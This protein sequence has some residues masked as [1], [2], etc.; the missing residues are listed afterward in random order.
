MSISSRSSPMPAPYPLT[1]RQSAMSKCRWVK[2]LR[3]L[4]VYWAVG[5]FL[6]AQRG[7]VHKPTFGVGK[8]GNAR[9]V[10][11][12]LLAGPIGHPRGTRGHTGGAYFCVGAG[13]NRHS[14]GLYTK[15][16]IALGKIVKAAFT[17]KKNHLAKR[18]PAQLKTNAQLGHAGRAGHLPLAIH[19]AFTVGAT[20][21]NGPFTN[22]REN[23][24]TVG[25]LKKLP[26][27][28]G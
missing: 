4:L 27:L 28:R 11:G 5:K 6:P 21:N 13:G 24:V 22:G 9:I 7:L 26:H 3:P 17:L 18:L 14:T 1:Q 16:K 8:H 20:D 19:S 15:F 2:A 10:G 12:H 25:G 23:S